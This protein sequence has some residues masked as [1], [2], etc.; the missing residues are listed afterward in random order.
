MSILWYIPNNNNSIGC[1]INSD[2]L[3]KTN[4][5]LKIVKIY[6]N[7]IHHSVNLDCYF[8]IYIKK[9]KKKYLI[10]KILIKKIL[11][12]SSYLLKKLNN[13][14]LHTIKTFLI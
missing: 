5:K 3:L 8:N 13:D 7:F 1:Q 12:V 6:T 11:I 14:C 2:N 10:K 9:F 4:E